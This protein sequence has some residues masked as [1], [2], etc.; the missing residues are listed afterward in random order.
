[1]I[2]DVKDTEIPVFKMS[3]ERE[4]QGL[5]AFED[6]RNGKTKEIVDFDAQI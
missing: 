6:H 1:M 4:K 3:E 2:D 5:E